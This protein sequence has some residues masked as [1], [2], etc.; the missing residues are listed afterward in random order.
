M[1]RFMFV[2][3]SSCMIFGQVFPSENPDSSQP[4]T[5]EAA[6]STAVQSL[7]SFAEGFGL[8][9]VN[10]GKT[11]LYGAGVGAAFL[12]LFG[13]LPQDMSV[14]KAV[15]CNGITG[16]F[17]GGYFGGCV[18]LLG[19][20]VASFATMIVNN[21]K[22]ERIKGFGALAATATAVTYLGHRVLKNIAEIKLRR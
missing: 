6:P 16:A 18:G 1:K 13:T 22:Q 4:A 14:G 2:V 5:E 9:C 17:I 20:T 21:D 15:L 19:G 8:Q 11:G 12:G 7:T 10:V 3:L